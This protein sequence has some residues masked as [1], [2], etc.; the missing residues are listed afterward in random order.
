M[1]YGAGFQLHCSPFVGPKSLPGT[2][3]QVIL[4]AITDDNLVQ[5]PI[6]TEELM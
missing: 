6:Y 4:V 1:V 5:V 2:P 3:F